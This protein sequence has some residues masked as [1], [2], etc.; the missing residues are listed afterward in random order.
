MVS[1]FPR[2]QKNLHDFCF[3]KDVLIIPETIDKYGRT[4]AHVRSLDG[5]DLSVEIIAAGLSWHYKKYSSSQLL[6][7]L[8]NK[9]KKNKIGLW[10]DNDPIAPWN[11]RNGIRNS[12]Q[13]NQNN[14]YLINKFHGNV[15]SKI[16][17]KST[18]KYYN[19]K[20]CINIFNSREEAI[21]QGFRPCGLCNP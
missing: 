8:E 17:H 16:F 12:N 5:S 19:C 18:C 21:L 11:W 14:A 10:Q 6:E 20:N 7:T 4:V 9:A 13:L 15:S 1:L 3:G 2:Q